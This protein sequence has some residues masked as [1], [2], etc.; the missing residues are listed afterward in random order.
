MRS[1]EGFPE[2]GCFGA[3]SG[4]AWTL[5][6]YFDVGVWGR[7]SIFGVAQSVRGTS[8]GGILSDF[9]GA[10]LTLDIRV[11]ADGTGGLDRCFG[12]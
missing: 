4:L 5:A 2:L 10:C 1:G 12:V 7:T 3:P 8:F 9:G 11:S 6:C